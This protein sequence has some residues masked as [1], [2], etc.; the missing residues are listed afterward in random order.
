V[1]II[2]SQEA[3]DTSAIRWVMAGAGATLVAAALMT[4]V[5]SFLLALAA[6]MACGTMLEENYRRGAY[7]EIIE[8][9]RDRPRRPPRINSRR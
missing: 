4:N 2:R 6:L 3:Y 1:K 5:L 9:S 8:E 7:A